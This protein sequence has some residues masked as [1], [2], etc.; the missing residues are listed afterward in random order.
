MRLF[1]YLELTTASFLRARTLI[2]SLPICL[3]S[4]RKRKNLA[5]FDKY[6][7]V[8]SWLEIS[9]RNGWNEYTGEHKMNDHIGSNFV[10]NTS[11]NNLDVTGCSTAVTITYFLCA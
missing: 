8:R 2:A 6:T 1:S 4:G 11:E 9:L 5:I 3:F 7:S 10:G